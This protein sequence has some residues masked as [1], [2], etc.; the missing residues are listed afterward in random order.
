[1]T[2]AGASNR[3]DRTAA[4]TVNSRSDPDQWS[5]SEVR[6]HWRHVL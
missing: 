2:R 3:R 1:M 4:A 5:D 6:K